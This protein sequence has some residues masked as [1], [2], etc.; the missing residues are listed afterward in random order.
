[1]K[2]PAPN[3][4]PPRPGRRFGWTVVGLA[5]ASLALFGV[6]VWLILPGTT[7]G[8]SDEPVVINGIAVPP[9]PTLNPQ[10]IADGAQLYAQYCAAC[11]GA[12]LK[13]AP[14]WKQPL[15]TGSYPPPPHDDTGH[16]WHH[17][18]EQ[19]MAIVNNG[20]DPAYNGTMP[21]FGEI[22]TIDQTTAIFDFIKS[23]WGREE[24]EHQ[25]WVTASRQGR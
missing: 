9:V 24:R 8:A 4:H 15:A 12:E 23:R 1:M 7:N 19:L 18:D 25:W 2:K 11:H 16:T 10:R 21:A 14:N 13:G 5:A 20:G 6:A 3:P 17:P 22:L